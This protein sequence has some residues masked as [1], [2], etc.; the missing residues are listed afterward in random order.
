VYDGLDTLQWVCIARNH[1]WAI[2][3]C[4]STLEKSVLTSIP[5]ASR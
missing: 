4:A 5:L 2:V 3:L 1:T